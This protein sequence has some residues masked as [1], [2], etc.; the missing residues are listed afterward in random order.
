MTPE[1]TPTFTSAPGDELVFEND[2]IR[3]WAMNL[4]AE[5]GTYEFHEH[6][7]DHLIL[8]PTAGRA[9][10]QDYGD[11]E[12]KVAQEAERGYAFFKTV[13]RGGPLPP[14]RLRNLEDHPVTHYIIELLQESPSEGP[15]PH[16]TNGRGTTTRP[17]TTTRF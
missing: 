1:P 10:G 16:E 6:H 15:L 2:R 17:H 3:V 11:D 13:G 14:H 7:H 4:E 5:G 12:W 8:W 9:Q